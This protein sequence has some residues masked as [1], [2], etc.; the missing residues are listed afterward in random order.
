M[1]AI[2]AAARSG[3]AISYSSNASSSRAAWPLHC[4]FWAAHPASCTMPSA[5]TLSDDDAS[6]E[7]KLEAGT[8]HG[9]QSV[10]AC[11]EHGAVAHSVD[12]QDVQA[13]HTRS[14]AVLQGDD[15]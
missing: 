5:V 8:G 15:S 14:L 12:E 4:A 6:Q 11:V 10:S 3:H 7:G 2:R 13:E 9:A 1:L